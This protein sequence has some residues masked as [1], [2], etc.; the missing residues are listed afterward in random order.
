MTIL[1]TGATGF[2]GTGLMARF[3]AENRLAR[4]TSRKPVR[5]LA[6]PIEWAVVGDQDDSTDWTTAL[7]G[8]R[9]VIHLAARVHIVR[10]GDAD[11]L[12]AFR[13]T[14]VQG[15][16]NLA[17]QAASVGVE[18]FVFVSTI[19]VNGESGTYR[20]SDP[21]TPSDA[22]GISKL[23]A[24]NGL[25][26]I[27]KTSGLAVVVIRPP[28]VYGPGARANFQALCRAIERG[29]PLP[30]G[31]IQ[32]RRS[33]VA[34]DN[35]VDFIVTCVDHPAA[36][37]ETFFVS[38]GEDMSTTTLIRRIAHVMKRPARLLRVPAN[39]LWAVA[40]VV[41]KRELAQRLLG[42][43]QLDITKARTLLEWMPPLTVDE[44]LR[45]A[46]GQRSPWSN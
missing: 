12:T 27:G 39:V 29:I 31:A 44:G 18:R 32:N 4:G 40:T 17:R 36:K 7:E 35:L 14:N 10:E 20:E 37:G 6:G 28:L 9:T 41:G 5:A 1:V 26:E 21:A 33:F 13:R 34:L 23:E 24:E 2:V 3:S 15:T 43:L 45:R 42:S 46:V 22:Y 11:P 25:R 30:L 19:K 38:D 8:V 16:L